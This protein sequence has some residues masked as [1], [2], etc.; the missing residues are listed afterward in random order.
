MTVQ[1][2]GG[3]PRG[4]IYGF[5]PPYMLYTYIDFERR[6]GA[7]Q[8]FSLVCSQKTKTDIFMQNMSSTSAR[9]FNIDEKTLKTV[10]TA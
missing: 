3:L 10:F 7:L 2:K 9:V 6:R 8:K 4:L 5:A 1:D